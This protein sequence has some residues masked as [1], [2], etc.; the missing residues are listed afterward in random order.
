MLFSS[1]IFLWLFL[2]IT[3]FL[4]RIVPQKGKNFFLL[5]MS[6]L[7]YFWGGIEYGIILLISI[8]VNYFV[9]LAI[10]KLRTNSTLC[11]SCFV[12]GILLNLLFL[13]YYKYFVFFAKSILLLIGKTEVVLED[14][15]LP[16]GISFYTFQ[17]LSYLIDLYKEKIDVQKNPIRLALYIAF[18]PQLIAGPIVKYIDI[19]NQIENRTLSHIQTATGIRRFSYGLA[20]KVIVA[21]SM[22]YIADMIFNTHVDGIS[23]AMA[24]IGAIAYSL[25]IYFDFSGYSDMAIGLGK[26]FG[27]DFAENFNMP[28]MAKSISDFWRRWHISMTSWFREYIYIPLGGNRL[29][30]YRTL[31]NTMI[32]FAVTGLWHGANYTFIVWGLLNG[33]LIVIERCGLADFLENDKVGILRHA[34]TLLLVIIGWVFF[35]ADN[36]QYAFAF[37]GRMFSCSVPQ[38]MGVTWYEILNTKNILICIVAVLGSGVHKSLLEKTK[39]CRLKNSWLETVYCGLLFLTS[40]ILLISDTYNPFIYFRF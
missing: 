35:R 32:V 5:I 21:N 38:V 28:Y 8:V 1:I 25:Q 11:K 36:L 18:F 30:L 2:P 10:D 12:G 3:F 39:L 9:G 15:E 24:W 14:V 29:G 33:L 23:S 13:F 22:A 4:Y 26:M 27:F 20:K 31:A 34:Y 6:F 7:F 17:A 19:S 40:I 37:I 16:L